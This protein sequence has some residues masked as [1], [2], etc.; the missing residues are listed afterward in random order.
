MMLLLLSIRHRLHVVLVL[1]LFITTML[2]PPGASAQVDSISASPNAALL[3]HIWT[4]RG[5]GGQ[6]VGAAVA[7]LWDIDG[8]GRDEFGVMELGPLIWRVVRLDSAG[9]EHEIWRRP[10]SSPAPLFH[11]NFRGD[12]KRMLVHQRERD[13]ALLST[14]YYLDFFDADSGRIAD[15]ATLKWESRSPGIRLV[16]TRFH[17]AD[18]D[19]DGADE[20]IVAAPVVVRNGSRS[21]NGEIWIYRGGPETVHAQ[22]MARSGSI[23]AVPISRSGRRRSSF[24]TASSMEVNTRYTSAASMTTIIRISFA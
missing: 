21:E 11:G 6:G 2:S 7:A 17:V 15:T 9:S 10:T 4:Q 3:H 12:G 5:G 19:L 22:R 23:G 24:V 16:G 18:L 8:D 1:G 14:L 13:T 20:L